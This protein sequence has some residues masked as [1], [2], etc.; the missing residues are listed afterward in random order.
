M[1]PTEPQVSE[2]GRY[3]ITQACAILQ[4]H[5]HTLTR[6]ADTGKIN[7]GVSKINHRRFFYGRDILRYWRSSL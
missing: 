5:R 2:T 4:I 3:S 7:Y 6:H 1:I